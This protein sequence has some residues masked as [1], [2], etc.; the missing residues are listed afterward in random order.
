MKNSKKGFIVPLLII[1]VAVLIV[2]GGI[3]IYQNNKK[4]T[5]T[6]PSNT[7]IGS[8]TNF[9]STTTETNS[10]IQSSEVSNQRTP[11]SSTEQNVT[12]NSKSQTN[13]NHL[14]SPSF[15][16]PT[17]LNTDYAHLNKP[18]VI[19][20]LDNANI[21]SNGC[22][23]IIDASKKIGTDAQ[24]IV[25]KIPFCRSVENDS[26]PEAV[27]I[28]NIVNYN[29]YYTTYINGEYLTLR[30]QVGAINGCATLKGQPEY[31]AC[32]TFENDYDSIV[33]KQLDQS[34]GTI[35]F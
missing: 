7:E 35:T 4:E 18:K 5:L 31:Q 8:M 28:S 13:T 1:I 19:L 24:I 16:F 3:Y 6:A 32:E 25:N 22:F 20:S 34:A 17:S 12:N 26:S 33:I 2:G 9:Q 11:V 10:N 15:N 29:Y 23:K 14:S 27:A 30:Y 21:D